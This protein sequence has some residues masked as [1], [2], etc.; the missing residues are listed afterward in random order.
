MAAAAAQRL[1]PSLL[2]LL[3]LLLLDVGRA[4]AAAASSAHPSLYIAANFRDNAATVTTFSAEL[5]KLAA[6]V[7]PSNLFVTVYESGSA[8]STPRLLDDARRSLEAAGVA[9]NITANG[10]LTRR[11]RQRIDFLADARNELLKPLRA[12]AHERRFD[13]V[14][15]VNDVLFEAG[16]VRKLLAVGADISCGTDFIPIGEAHKIYRP[17]VDEKYPIFYDSWVA[18][19]LDGLPLR[20]MPPYVAPESAAPLMRKVAR[21]GL[22]FPEYTRA[23]NAIELAIVEPQPEVVQLQCCWNGIVVVAAAPFYSGLTFRSNLPGECGASECSHFCR[24][25]RALNYTRV[26]MHHGVR[27]AYD[28]ETWHRARALDVP[29]EAVPLPLA[30]ARAPSP[31]TLCCGV[32]HIVRQPSYARDRDESDDAF[33]YRTWMALTEEPA[34]D[35]LAPFLATLLAGKGAL[36]PGELAS[37]LGD[38]PRAACRMTD[39]AAAAA[40]PCL[41]PAGRA[42]PLRLTQVG[43]ADARDALTPQMWTWRRLHPDHEYEFVDAF[44]GDGSGDGGLPASVARLVPALAARNHTDLAADLA[45]HAL[46]LDRGGIVADLDSVAGESLSCALAAGETHVAVFAAGRGRRAVALAAVPGHAAVRARLEELLMRADRVLQAEGGGGGGGERDAVDGPPAADLPT[47]RRIDMD[48]HSVGVSVWQPGHGA[49]ARH[50]VDAS[51][52]GRG[53]GELF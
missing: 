4:A 52:L 27:V 16:D 14:V 34:G 25:M 1:S 7:G 5:L 49:R 8:D 47:P 15:F 20:A 13:R 23:V 44:A 30:F 28:N 19:T 50:R 43:A 35:G 3:L 29:Y 9:T 36:R 26:A 22:S 12:M 2:P 41:A 17:A 6:D 39:S 48:A 10:P 46:L 32:H 42:V 53:L 24:D 33:A 18:R 31:R 38:E 40:R 45:R 51:G 37:F 21:L 11:G